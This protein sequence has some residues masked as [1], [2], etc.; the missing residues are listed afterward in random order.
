LQFDETALRQTQGGGTII[1]AP[2]ATF[3][4]AW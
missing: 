4:V 2:L 1:P 3:P